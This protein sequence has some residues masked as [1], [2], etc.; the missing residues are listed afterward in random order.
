[1]ITVER[2]L[3]VAAPVST[4]WTYLSD[5]TA[6][7]EWDPGTV[8]TTRIGEGPLAV[9]SRFRNV[10]EFRGRQTELDYVIRR[11]ETDRHLR[12]E[13]TNKTVNATDDMSFA[14]SASGGTTV[15]YRAYFEFKGLARLA[16][17]LLRRGYDRAAAPCARV[18]R[19]AR[20]NGD[21]DMDVTPEPM[22]TPDPA[23][24]RGAR[25]TEF[26]GF[27]EA[28]TQRAMPD[29]ATLQRWS[30]EDLDVF[31]RTVWDF[32][33]IVATQGSDTALAEDAMPGATWFP[34]AALNLV[35]QIFRDRPEIDADTAIA[36]IEADESGRY[37][38]RRW[39]D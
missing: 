38:A 37:A 35:D 28:R 21:G 33:D 26:A 36:V 32:F 16:E 8:T 29:Y 25:I 12:F 17:P 30:V 11:F 10:S 24:V 5:F 22:W 6:T 18:T 20:L 14:P 31:W 2:S 27:V 34:G 23:A 3:D 15:I 1:M 13:G 7:E 19:D 4:V 39:R 9:G